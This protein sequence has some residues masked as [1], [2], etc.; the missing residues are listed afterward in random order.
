M[1]QPLSSHQPPD[2]SDSSVAHESAAD[3]IAGVVSILSDAYDAPPV[4]RSL[5]QKLDEGIE[6]QWGQSPALVPSRLAGTAALAEA[7]KSWIRSWPVAAGLAAVVTLA[8]VFGGGSGSY[9]WAAVIDAIKRQGLVRI[10]QGDSV[11]WLDLGRQV[12]GR[13]T[14][15]ETQWIDLRKRVVLTRT[16]GSRTLTRE[17]LAISS[18]T[19]ETESL[20]AAFLLD[21]PLSGESL[22]RLSGVKVVDQHWDKRTSEGRE[23]VDLLVHLQT[24]SDERF[25]LSMRLDPN[26]KLP[27]AIQG[28]EGNVSTQLVSLAYPDQSSGELQASH[29]PANLTIVDSSPDRIAARSALDESEAN[30]RGGLPHETKETHAEGD[31]PNAGELHH[32]TESDHP[33]RGGKETDGGNGPTD[34]R[35]RLV[36]TLPIGAANKWCAGYG[37]ARNRGRGVAESRS[38]FGTI[39]AS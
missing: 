24:D 28:T 20:L 1:K 38:Y 23:I 17:P 30:Q 8:F 26:S 10:D 5:V 15:H 9:A 27:L 31:D 25:S 7:G 22:D 39:V 29:F 11:R 36:A 19:D 2:D 18:E 21:Q 13:Q 35:D 34:D 3:D 32:V 14:R 33:I 37:C 6:T 12:A 4:P 16:T